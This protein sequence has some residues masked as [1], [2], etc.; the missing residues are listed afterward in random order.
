MPDPAIRVSQL[1]KR[2]Q[3]GRRQDGYRTFREAIIDAVTTP[4]RRLSR[5][6]GAAPS[7]HEIWALQDVSFEV[8]PGEVVGIIGRNGAGK[9]T[10]LKILSHITE[11][12]RGR[13]EIR[14]R[15]ASLLEVGTGFHSELTGRENVH[16]NGAI[17]GMTRREIRGKF[18]QIVAF[19]ELEPFLDTPVKRYSTGMYL[20]LAFAV[21]AHLQPDI[22]VVDEILAVGDAGF[23]RKC[24]RRMEDVSKEGA[25]VLLVSHQ[26]PAV[27]SL[28]SR[29]LQLHSGALV[30]DGL[31]QDVVR[32]YLSDGGHAASSGRTWQNPGERPGH[33]PFSLVSLRAVGAA[34]E[35]TNAFPSS[36]PI[37]VEIEF[38]LEFLHSALCIAFDLISRD[39]HTVFRSTHNDREEAEWPDLEVGRNR[40]RCCIPPGMLSFGA[41]SVAP[42]VNLHGMDWLLNSDPLVSFEVQLDHSRS[43]FWNA[44]NPHK[45]PGVIAPCLEWQAAPGPGS[46]RSSRRERSVAVR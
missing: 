43:P 30:R 18:D 20:R 39:G 10:L 6:P 41:Y 11:P 14:G 28:C 17:L 38:D 3:I 29:A 22:L 9:S 32:H 4:V 23:Q 16:L 40:L 27:K 21:A 42:K 31:P 12:T 5:L 7:E 34:G 37:F 1:G 44:V 46:E 24:L 13:V 15:V 45:H 25:T 26:M 19:A 33:S 36:E 35:A 2:Y 8:Q